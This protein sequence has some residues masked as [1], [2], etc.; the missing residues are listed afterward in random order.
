MADTQVIQTE[1]AP[2]VPSE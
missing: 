1:I 2:S